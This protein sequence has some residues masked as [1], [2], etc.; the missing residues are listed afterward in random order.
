MPY[1]KQD[2]IEKSGLADRTIR[3]YIA[4]GLLPRPVGHGLGAEYDDV[5]MVRAVAIGR[6]RA[7][8]LR[9]AD[10]TERIA[11]WKTAQFKRFVAKTEPPAPEP[12]PAAEPS[13]D[14]AE[15]IAR[16]EPPEA[17][18]GLREPGPRVPRIGETPNDDGGRGEPARREVA[19]RASLRSTSRDEEIAD[20]D[21]PEA[22]C[23]RIYSL[24]T[25]IGLMVDVD[26]PPIVQR[27]AAEILTRYGR[28]R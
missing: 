9:I 15:E 2:L 8:G 24:L 26:A 4:R 10:I 1:T 22:P 12:P 25:G 13:P 16:P 18:R 14:P 7:E 19:G 11:G 5:H 23:W 3:T 28:T 27:I 6:M 20:S 17:P 21:L